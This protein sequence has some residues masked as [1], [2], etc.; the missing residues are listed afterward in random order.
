MPTRAFRSSYASCGNVEAVHAARKKAGLNNAFPHCD[1]LLQEFAALLRV[2]GAAAK[3][4]VNK[5]IHTILIT[6]KELLDCD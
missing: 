4:T 6:S 2:A 5:V 3:D 1:P